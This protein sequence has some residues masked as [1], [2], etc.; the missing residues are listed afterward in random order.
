MLGVDTCTM[1][2][3]LG[4]VISIWLLLFN[5]AGIAVCR[6][7]G[8]VGHEACCFCYNIF[9]VLCV[10]GGRCIGLVVFLC[11][12]CAM[13]SCRFSGCGDYLVSFSLNK[14]TLGIC[15]GTCSSPRRAVFSHSL[16]C[17]KNTFSIVGIGPIPVK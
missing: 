10:S 2:V 3:A 14:F 4:H 9:G 15:H 5:S 6:R 16:V 11:N 13:I 7:N 12:V 1:I 8:S 17:S